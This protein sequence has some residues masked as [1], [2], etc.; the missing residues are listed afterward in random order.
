MSA[1]LAAILGLPTDEFVHV[2]GGTWVESREP[3]G[4]DF[5]ADISGGLGLDVTPWHIAGEPPQLMIRV[6]HHGAFMASPQGSWSAGP[7]MLTYHPSN[8]TYVGAPELL[9]RG[10]DVVKRLLNG[11]RRSFR[12]CRYCLNSYPPEERLTADTCYGCA[13]HFEGVIY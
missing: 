4:H 11:R 1:K 6:F 12:Y 5:D 9:T 3:P 8:E 10:V 13:T 2:L 7:G